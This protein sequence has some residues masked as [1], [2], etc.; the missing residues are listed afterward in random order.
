M[1]HTRCIQLNPESYHV[2][3]LCHSK[4]CVNI[5]HLSDAVHLSP[6]DDYYLVTDYEGNIGNMHFLHPIPEPQ[7][8]K[9]ELLQENKNIEKQNLVTL[10]LMFDCQD[11]HVLYQ[12]MYMTKMH[13][14]H[15]LYSTESRKFC[16]KLMDM[17]KKFYKEHGQ[18]EPRCE[19]LCNWN[20]N[21]CQTLGDR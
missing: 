20:T 12:C 3:H 2:S 17:F 4:T 1:I 15:T 18:N 9:P 11:T 6:N 16:G 13:D 14:S 8:T 10:L 5:L 7:V 19:L 21:N